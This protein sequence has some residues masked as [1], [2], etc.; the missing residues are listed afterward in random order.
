M[1]HKLFTLLAA[2]FGISSASASEGLYY[3]GSEAQESLPLK[4]TVGADLTYDDNVTPTSRGGEQDSVSLGAYVGVSFVNITPQQTL[5]VYARLGVQY[6]LDSPST[7]SDDWF[8]QVRIGVNW[9]RR[10][11]ERLRFSSRNF[12]SY[13]LEP[14]YAFGFATNRQIDP[15][16]YWQTDNSIGFR[17]TERL[18]SYTGFRLTGLDY[19]SDVRNQDRFTWGVYHQFR[20]QLTPQT[21]LTADYRY[22]DTTG[23][24]AASDQT[25][26]YLLGGVEHRFS[27]NTIMI[28]RAGAQWNENDRLGS[29]VETNPF[30]ELAVRSKI[31]SQFSVRA[32]A[33]YSSEVFDTARTVVT[34]G[35][36]NIYDFTDRRT[37]RIGL[38]AEYIISPTWSLFGGVDYIPATFDDGLY[39]GPLP[40]P[41]GAP[42][43]VT[44]I[45]ETLWNAY[46]GC[47]VRITD[48]VYGT[49]SYNYTDSDSDF[50][51][52]SYDRNRVTLG[53]RTEF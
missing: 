45:E 1:N 37:L 10:F 49:L 32:F 28:L 46:I 29:D 36:R 14:N 20:Y 43:S 5:D 53:V 23:D 8:P 30:L 13:E 39:A 27:P 34:P 25:S 17:W 41:A 50:S 21:V 12:V 33:R 4:W 51:G 44:G 9:T 38:S 47:S 52:F 7:L 40:R 3:V 11:T 31:N 26:H 16:F 22:T 48:S 18:G 15:Y 6:Y 24:G 2:A 35:G 42:V 19:D